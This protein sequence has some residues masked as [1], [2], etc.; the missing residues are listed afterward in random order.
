MP[1]KRVAKAIEEIKQGKMVI[2]VDDE[3][4]ENEG[5]LVFAAAFSTPEKVNFMASRAKGLI[6]A[7][8]EA[9]I[10]RRLDLTPMVKRNEEAL[11]TAFTV[12]VDAAEA[13]TG[14]SAFERD[15]TIKVLA[16]PL[17]TATDL[18]R[19]G[20]IFPLVAKEGGV[21][22]R[23]GHTEGA[24]DLCKLAG[25]QGSAVICEIMKDDGTMAR[26]DD[27]TA[28]ASEHG[29]SIVYI[30]DLV[31]YRLQ[32]E[33][34]VRVTEETETPFQGANVVRYGF[35]DHVGRLHHAYRFGEITSPTLVKFH[36]I[37][38][39]LELLSQEEQFNG[40]M[41]AIEVLKQE[42]GV[43]VFLKGESEHGTTIREFGIGAQILKA[44]RI[45]HL[46][47]LTTKK[48]GGFFGLGGF[49]LEIEAERVIH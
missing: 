37:G 8:V 47:L 16:D 9:E 21:L 11:G 15:M 28:F 12:S 30:A 38:S 44:L 33:S 26:R 46:T 25:L 45:S 13:T 42:G 6:C 35:M 19:P 10:A 22:T 32:K 1:L 4:R 23:T 7:P 49:G 27:L 14:I 31:E 34:L 20:H 29:L 2:M 48:V 3:D 36:N 24:V 40:M 18:V 5:D 41:G 43:L 39:D 17:A